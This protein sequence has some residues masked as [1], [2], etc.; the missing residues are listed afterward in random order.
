MKARLFFLAAALGWLP[1]SLHAETPIALTG[2]VTSV[3]E[4]PME[5]VLVSAMSVGQRADGSTVTITVVSD[6]KGRFRFPSSKMRPG[7]YGLRIRAV[8]YDLEGPG[9][10]ETTAGKT[11]T[12]DLKLHKAADPAAQLSNAEWLASLPGTA[13]QKASVRNC[14]HCHT[15]ERIMRS[16]FNADV[17]VPVIERMSTYPQLSFPLMPQKL[18]APR[19]GGGEDPL[20]QK[21]EGWRRQAAYLSTVNLGH[22]IVD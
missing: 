15:M 20:E 6:D 9:V 5:G 14:T 3:E 21:M 1:V 18:V 8:G 16:R 11:T 17:F 7:R 13:Q 2:Q 19:I 12:A 10:I 22:Y 4:G